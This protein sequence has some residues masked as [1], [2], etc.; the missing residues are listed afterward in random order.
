MNTQHE[1]YYINM[2]GANFFCIKSV[3]L[4][5]TLILPPPDVSTSHALLQSKGGGFAVINGNTHRHPP[6][7]LSRRQQL[8][9]RA[10]AEK[11]QV[12]ADQDNE[13]ISNNNPF[14]N[15]DNNV[16]NGNY[17]QN[18][19]INV[20]E[21][22]NN[23]Y[24]YPTPHDHTILGSATEHIENNNNNVNYNNV[25]EQVQAAVDYDEI[26][27]HA[28]SGPN[29]IQY[30]DNLSSK[31]NELLFPTT[32]LQE[33]EDQVVVHSNNKE[34]GENVYD[35][36]L[37]H[38]GPPNAA[39]H[40]FRSKF[41]G[42]EV[43]GVLGEEGVDSNLIMSSDENMDD[44]GE[45]S[46]DIESFEGSKEEYDNS[47]KESTNDENTDSSTIRSTMAKSALLHRAGLVASGNKSSRSKGRS[48]RAKPHVVKNRRGSGSGGRAGAM[49]RVL[50]TVR[51]AAAAAATERKK[52]KSQS[53]EGESGKD[54][55]TASSQSLFTAKRK[56]RPLASKLKNSI[57]STVVGML[58]KQDL[59]IQEESVHESLNTNKFQGGNLIPQ[60]VPSTSMGLLGE[61]MPTQVVVDQQLIPQIPPLPGVFLVGTNGDIPAKRPINI[62]TSIPH[63]SDDTHI[64]NLRLSVFSRFDEH[65]QR[66]FRSRSVEVLNVRRRRGAVVLVAETPKKESE[67]G[68]E[69]QYL[70]E[71][72]AR[73]AGGHQY[74]NAPTNVQP[75]A[76]VSSSPS[77][78][79][80][81]GQGARITSVS[82]GVVVD[83][84]PSSPTLTVRPGKGAR[85]TSVSPGVA[86]DNSSIIGSIECSHQEFRGTM[87]GN[88]R[89]KGSLMYVTEVAVKTD[90]RRSGAGAMLM[91][92]VDEVAR[93]RNVET[94]YLHVDV[95]NQA[96]C[97]MYEKC[98]YHYLDKREVLY[99]QF[100]ASL[101]LHD[102]AMHGRKHYLMCKNVCEKTTW[103]DD[104]IDIFA[105]SREGELKELLA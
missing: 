53:T 63:S 102:G 19:N 79:I 60:V 57:Q 98:G 70:N 36:I 23:N 22:P 30:L 96:A 24:L 41:Y 89:P 48:S 87:L 20:V 55:L 62:R 69:E 10:I 80:R 35:E 25:R 83:S 71:M 67:V 38:A 37:F 5:L 40:L 49:G 6:Y 101:N 88:C 9:L 74:G 78:T 14:N 86:V 12:E 77:L 29:A 28:E 58:K 91:R 99:A 94:I 15:I 1:N 100:T 39:Q 50:G 7:A 17:W 51:T 93:I 52:N 95:T 64:A 34:N 43:I 56:N 21:D 90:A 92:G 97:N 45:E 47:E 27:F 76:P 65:Q 84:T 72:H 2:R 54:N 32:Q 66:V 81:P 42:D 26:L 31:N 3:G 85:V 18:D 75:E 44:L 13:D 8:Q 104:D 46:T 16:E 61:P 103:L 68:K 105:D 73:I 59:A 4:T 11:P 82:P 33:V